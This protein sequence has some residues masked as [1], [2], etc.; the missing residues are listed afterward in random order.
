L[1]LQGPINAVDGA[2][3]EPGLHHGQVGKILGQADG[4]PAVIRHHKHHRRERHANPICRIEPDGACGE[5][6]KRGLVLNRF[7]DDKA[8]EHEQKLEAEIKIL[9]GSAQ[10]REVERMQPVRISVERVME[11]HD[12]DRGHEPKQIEFVEAPVPAR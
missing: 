1:N 4:E 8:A 5:K 11:H 10:R 9:Q 2:K 3:A 6:A 7:E 12:R